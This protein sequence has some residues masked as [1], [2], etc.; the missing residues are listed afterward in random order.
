MP[1][2][3]PCLDCM[4]VCIYI[5]IYT[6][7]YRY[8]SRYH[9]FR[10]MTI[11]K[12]VWRERLQAS[13]P[14]FKKNYTIRIQM[15]RHVWAKDWPHLRYTRTA[16]SGHC[17][18]IGGNTSSSRWRDRELCPLCVFLVDGSGVAQGRLVATRHSRVGRSST[19][20]LSGFV[21][22]R[23][24]IR[25]VGVRCWDIHRMISSCHH[26]VFISSSEADKLDSPVR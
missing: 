19:I 22:S 5:Y 16:R 18:G 12:I 20:S 21:S 6:Y 10:H 17:P 23:R 15:H 3:M 14:C 13:T 11:Y 26:M 8:I 24:T 4:C 7:V 2:S 9:P 25:I 1:A